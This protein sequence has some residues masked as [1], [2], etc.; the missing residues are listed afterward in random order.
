M[1]KMISSPPMT[2]SRWDGRSLGGRFGHGFFLVAISALGRWPTYF[3]LAFV[4]PYYCLFARKAVRASRAYLDR[5]L[6]PAPWPVRAWRTYRHFFAFGTMLI[7]RFVFYTYGDGA[8][9]YPPSPWEHVEAALEKKKG[10]IFLS[11]HVGAWEI[12][13]AVRRRFERR[14]L[15]TVLNI[16]M[17]LPAGQN[18]PSHV[19]KLAQEGD[20]HVISIQ[21]ATALPF[22]VV[23]A[24]ERGEIVA[25]HG[26]RALSEATV[27]VEFL[28][29]KA[30]FPTGPWAVAA[31]TGAPV[32]RTFLL[33]EGASAY[34]FV[35]FP[36][37]EVARVARSERAAE[38]R[39]HVETYARELEGLVREHPYQ[40]FNFYD[41]WAL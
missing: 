41:F 19:E 2:D 5:V 37:I 11:A 25:F 18:V 38:I 26:D 35:A 9:R 4:V 17:H 39:K 33:K 8:F 30:R 28:G 23:G 1:G 21:D 32:V 12:A 3:C 29:A 14:Q 13:A 6:G 27:E 36:A 40:W 20:L 10:A 7:D 15:P 34:R 16:V 31:A 22:E 24:L